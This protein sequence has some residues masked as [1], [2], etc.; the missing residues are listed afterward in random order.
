MTPR[1]FNITVTEGGHDEPAVQ[2]EIAEVAT[3]KTP[4]FVVRRLDA[5]APIFLVEADEE[6]G[7]ERVSAFAMAKIAGLKVAKTRKPKG[8]SAA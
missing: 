3:A 7:A 8:E 6:D 1:I 4:T 5:A 2:I